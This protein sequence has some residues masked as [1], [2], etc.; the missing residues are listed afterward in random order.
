MVSSSP[1]ITFM[2]WTACPDAPLSRLSRAVIRMN[3]PSAPAELTDMVQRLV[4]TTWARVAN[5]PASSIWMK[6]S[7]PY[8]S[9]HRDRSLSWLHDGSTET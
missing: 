9:R 1:N 4:L 3:S 2:F 8:T 7:P 5:L 6:G